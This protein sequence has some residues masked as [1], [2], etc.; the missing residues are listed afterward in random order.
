MDHLQGEHDRAVNIEK[1]NFKSMETFNNWKEEEERKTK[2]YY[3]QHSASKIVG[4]KKI[5]YLFCN[6]SG[7]PRFR[8]KGERQ[9]K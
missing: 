2:S 1:L 5:L 7:K 9:L 4:N 3:A 8:G 6:R